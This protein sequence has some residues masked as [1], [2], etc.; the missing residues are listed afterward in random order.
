ME[1]RNPATQW[2]VTGGEPQ[3]LSWV[4]VGMNFEPRFV[5]HLEALLARVVAPDGSVLLDPG[6]A[7]ITVPFGPS[8]PLLPGDYAI[9]R[10]GYSINILGVVNVGPPFSGL[11][12]FAPTSGYQRVVAVPELAVLRRLMP[13]KHVEL[14][15]ILN[16]PLQHLTAWG[17]TAMLQAIRTPA[18]QRGTH[19]D[20]S[21]VSLEVQE[22][23]SGLYSMKWLVLLALFIAVFVKQSLPWKVAL[24][25]AAP[26][27]ALEAN[28]LRVAATGVSLEFV[29]HPYKD[30]MGWGAMALGVVQ[31]V[32]LGRL[33]NRRGSVGLRRSARAVSCSA[34]AS[35]ASM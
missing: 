13:R 28:M 33:M 12:S 16:P 11:A 32:G 29:G 4:N 2:T 22:W 17:A 25:L 27:V 1:N 30:W 5:L 20:L 10:S 19:V 31:V 34:S 8:D 26:L 3:A 24:V 23:C 15:A 18:V 35:R 9:D 14:A 7:Q 21:S 6:V